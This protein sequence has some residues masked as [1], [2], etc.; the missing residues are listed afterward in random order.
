MTR[1][2]VVAYRRVDG[3]Y[4]VGIRRD[5]VLVAAAWTAGSRRDAEQIVRELIDELESRE[6]A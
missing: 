6:A 4:D 5:G 1:R 3:G 2:W